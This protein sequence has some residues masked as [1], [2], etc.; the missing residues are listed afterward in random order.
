MS[1]QIYIDFEYNS[2]SE[3]TLNLVCV[4]YEIFHDNISV[5]KDCRW[6]LDEATRLDTARFI[7]SLLPDHTVMSFAMTAEARSIFDLC[8]WVRPTDIKGVD[9]QLNYRMLLNHNDTIAYGKQLIKGREVTT[10]KPKPKWLRSE[11]DLLD[12]S[13]KAEASLAA[14]TYKL[15][16]VKIDTDRKNLM[17]DIIIASDPV[18]IEKN[19][20]EI[21]EYCLSDIEYMPRILAKQVGILKQSG[22]P[23][24]KLKST[25]YNMSDYACYTAWM[26]KVGYPVQ[27]DELRKFISHIPDIM[28]IAADKVNQGCPDVKAFQ[29]NTKAQQYVK[30]ERP[31]R[32][33]ID[34]TPFAKD[35]LQTDG[36][37]H[38]LKREAFEKHYDVE[39][40]EFGNHMLRW[41][42]TKQSL[43]GFSPKKSSRGSFLD[44]LGSDG[45]CRPYFGIYG[46]QSSRSQPK[47]TSYLFL[48]AKWMR[49][50][51]QPKKGKAITGIDYGS[52]EFL[53]AAVLSGDSKMMRAYASGDPYI[54]FGKDAGIVPQDATAE[55]HGKDRDVLKTCVL[56]TSYDQ[57]GWGL[58]KVL[59]RKTDKEWTEEEANELIEKFYETYSVYS[60]WKSELIKDYNDDGYLQ[61]SDGWTMFGDNDNFRSVG[62]C[63]TQGMGAVI[64]REAVKIAFSRGLNVIL[65]LHDAVYIEHD[66]YDTKAII[67]LMCSMRRAFINQFPKQLTAA[68]SIRLDGKAWSSDYKDKMPIWGEN[69]TLPMK[70][71]ERYVDERG[72][73][74][75]NTYRRFLE[76]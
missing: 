36:G 55:S 30:K 61:L 66:S 24:K 35:W 19:K 26:T 49:Y 29:F 8:P 28:N 65:T 13:S 52:Q 34:T 10:R 43:N 7:A 73:N 76:T 60:E 70:F 31:I 3:E 42:K 40:D 50:F 63:P 27:V 18:E 62:N 46:S 20:K 15:L 21:M 48:K 71:S 37:K 22:I 54:A 69:P 47:A 23:L 4:A 12:N 38:S 58:A 72:Q 44:Y 6:L 9:L 67:T 5:L 32:E 11:K 16:G 59:T 14:C 57:T 45:R 64:M 74:D 1:K 2:T 39:G 53:I 75:L 25:M 17:R 56:A 68:A 51:V 33:W 41:L